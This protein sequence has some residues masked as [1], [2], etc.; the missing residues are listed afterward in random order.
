MTIRTRL[1]EMSD[2]EEDPGHLPLPQRMECSREVFR[3]ADFERDNLNPQRAGRRLDFAH[4]QHRSG[5]IGIT[6]DR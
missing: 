3:S 6:H 5:I 2:S 1:A 4:L